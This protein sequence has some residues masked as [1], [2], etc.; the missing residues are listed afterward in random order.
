MVLMKWMLTLVLAAAGMASWPAGSLAKSAAPAA[1]P[2]D[3]VFHYVGDADAYGKYVVF[4]ATRQGSVFYYCAGSIIDERFVL[5]AAHCVTPKAGATTVYFGADMRRFQRGGKGIPAAEIRINPR[6]FEDAGSGQKTSLW[7]QDQHE[8]DLAVIKL[9]RDIPADYKPVAL[10]YT[11]THQADGHFSRVLSGYSLGY[12]DIVT[13]S[14]KKKLDIRL[15][16][17][18]LGGLRVF[19]YSNILLVAPDKAAYSVCSGNS[20]GP[21]ILSDG[22]DTPRQIG[23]NSRADP[24]CQGSSAPAPVADSYDWIRDAMVALKAANPVPARPNYA[25]DCVQR[26]T[27]MKITGG[28]PAVQ[29]TITNACAAT[30]R[31]IDAGWFKDDDSQRTLFKNPVDLKPGQ[32][33]ARTLPGVKTVSDEVGLAACSSVND[34]DATVSKAGP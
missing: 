16:R 8:A 20:G 17:K 4:I 18:D 30:V 13:Q 6:Y 14:G 28:K 32:V 15:K 3:P 31:C 34:P 21:V 19:E 33:Y 1:P 9:S 24:K 5:T 7:W 25:G 27:D 2:R 12:G 29:I 11:T 22:A 10:D 23:V 26:A